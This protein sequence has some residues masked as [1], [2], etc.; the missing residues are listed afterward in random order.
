MR[1]QWTCCW[2]TGDLL[3]T[4]FMWYNYP[5]NNSGG[6]WL[7]PAINVLIQAVDAYHADERAEDIGLYFDGAYD[8]SCCGN[9]WSHA[10]AEDGE[11]VPSIYDEAL[12]DHVQWLRKD[13]LGKYYAAIDI[14]YAITYALD[15]TETRYEI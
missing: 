4:E 7:G 6:K 3:M 10:W 9:R 12:E 5:Q 2:W 8:C 1:P 13:P 15:G 14:P 11:S